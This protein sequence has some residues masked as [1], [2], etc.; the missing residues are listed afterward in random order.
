MGW[1]GVPV[2]PWPPGKRTGTSFL[3][4]DTP[5]PGMLAGCF[6]TVRQ[7]VDNV[8]IDHWPK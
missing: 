5:V 3:R 8:C 7:L 6:L 2:L 1:Y 4:K